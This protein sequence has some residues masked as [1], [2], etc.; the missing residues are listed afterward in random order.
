[1]VMLRLPMA[2]SLILTDLLAT[3]QL[4]N[5]A[6]SNTFP[7]TPETQQHPGTLLTKAQNERKVQIYRRFLAYLSHGAMHTDFS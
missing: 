7:S 6:V 5:G 1:M 2:M 4:Y 3:R